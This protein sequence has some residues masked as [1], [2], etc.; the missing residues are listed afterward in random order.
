MVKK[1]G[2]RF[3]YPDAK[4]IYANEQHPLVR[5]FSTHDD[6]IGTK[7]TFDVA[8]AIGTGTDVDGLHANGRSLANALGAHELFRKGRV[9][10]V[11]LV[12]G[13]PPD[14]GNVE[15]LAML[16]SLMQFGQEIP[17]DNL[18]MDIRSRSTVENAVN[19]LEI[20]EARKWRSAIILAEAMHAGR[21]RAT[22][23][24]QWK[25][26]DRECLVIR[27]FGAYGASTGTHTTPVSFFCREMA[28]RAYSRYKGWS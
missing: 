9:R 21:V 13:N 11:M 25:G 20:M 19:A 23:R 14:R 10:N 15:A 4:C 12:G 8:I 1:D 24:K 5:L 3:E 26:L 7:R 27:T 6:L 2:Y 22:F 28:V 17:S 18:A 16:R